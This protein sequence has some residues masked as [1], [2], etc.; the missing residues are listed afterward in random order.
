MLEI[1]LPALDIRLG[2][3]RVPLQGLLELFLRRLCTSE[4][5]QERAHDEVRPSSAWIKKKGLAAT[6]QRLP[7]PALADEVLAEEQLDIGAPGQEPGRLLEPRLC[8]LQE[9]ELFLDAPQSDVGLRVARACGQGR[10]QRAG[11][12]L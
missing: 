1:E 4:A 12:P 9:A 8:L 6:F 5:G 2:P 3:R 11:R 7:L 10:L